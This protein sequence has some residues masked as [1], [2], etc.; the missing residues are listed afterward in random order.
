[1]RRGA[2]P[3]LLLLLLPFLLLLATG[4]GDQANP[5]ERALIARQKFTVELVSWA[6]VANG[7]LALD[8][9]V[10]VEGQS[11]LHRLTVLIRQVGPE[12]EELQADLV[13]V[14]V[15]GMGF[16]GR[17]SVT[18]SVPA[19]AGVQAVAVLVESPPDPEQRSRYPELA[20]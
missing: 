17:K 7:R 3:V 13:P 8:V 2:S 11:D 9:T 19:A 1:M 18:L 20:G 4:C 10:L 5:L 15:E 14:D 6:P 12:Q 16:D